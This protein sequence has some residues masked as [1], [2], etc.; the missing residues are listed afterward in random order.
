[1]HDAVHPGQ[2]GGERGGVEQVGLDERRAFGHGL[3]VAAVERV[4]HGDVVPAGEQPLGDDRAD[5]AG[6][7]GHEKAHAG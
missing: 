4:E 6:S 1:M 5:V 7:A 2:G 3:A